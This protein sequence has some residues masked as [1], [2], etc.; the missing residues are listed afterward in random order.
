MPVMA[1]PMV[2]VPVSAAI[3][4]AEHTLY[5]ANGSADACTDSAAD[6]T[7]NRTGCALATIGAFTRAAH[8]ALCMRGE[9]QCQHRQNRK[10]PKQT[11]LLGGIHRQ[12]R[13]F[14]HSCPISI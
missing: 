11:P 2:I 13:C 9:G 7:A 10:S 14:H 12:N 5:A 4:N 3:R 8:N 6:H 1:M